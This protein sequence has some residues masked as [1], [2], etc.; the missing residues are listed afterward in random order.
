MIFKRLFLSLLLFS[1][2]MT[3]FLFADSI[4][5]K[6]GKKIEGRIL[7]EEENS[8]T[9]MTAAT[10]IV[11]ARAN[12]E[13]I[14]RDQV[15]SPNE[16]QGDIAVEDKRYNDALSYYQAALNETQNKESLQ[17]KIAELQKIQE[18][19]VSRRFGQQLKQA[20]RLLE[21]KDFDGA[22]SLLKQILDTLPNESLAKPVKDKLAHLYYCRALE[23]QNTVDD[24]KAFEFLKKSIAASDK[25]YEARLMIADILA[26]NP[27]NNDQ[28]VENYLSGLEA[29]GDKLSKSDK[30]R[31]HR[32]VAVI[33]EQQH[34]YME[35]IEQHKFILEL[36]PVSFPDTKER[37]V[38]AYCYLAAQTPPSDYNKRLEYLTAAVETDTYSTTAR[39]SLAY[40]YYENNKIE[41]SI[42]QWTHLINMNARITGIHYYLGMCYLKQKKYENAKDSFERELALDPNNYDALCAIGDY[43]LT[44]GKYE[45]AIANYEKAKN[46]SIEKYRAY[47]GLARAYKKLEQPQQARENLDLVFK[48]NPEHIEATIL[49]GALY[50]DDKDH[51]KARELFDNVVSRLKEKGQLEDPESKDLLIEALNQ[52]GELNLILDSPRIALADF[53]EALKYQPDFAESFYLIAQA[54][55]KMSN[56]KEAEENYIKAQMLDPKNP[57]YYLGLGILYHT[58]MKETQKAVPQYTKYIELGGEDFEKVNDWIKECGGQPVSPITH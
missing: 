53:N 58:K 41:D 38:T 10:S 48:T 55:S 52:R 5:M 43:Y 35:A 16:I 7:K 11:I 22:E 47:L 9:I 17:K 15:L 50:K 33:F 34:K 51:K 26:N 42:N 37:I 28:A 3:S 8:I 14:E 32:K 44:G 20:D 24:A 49:S 13:S 27:K 31:Y 23:Y 45:Q 6:N 57:K 2:F 19:E 46:V 25:A 30:A 36:D 56:F 40:F 54:H 21:M 29:A 1:T 4:I 18:E 12:I 39:Y